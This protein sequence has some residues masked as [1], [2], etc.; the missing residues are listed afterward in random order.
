MNR[1]RAMVAAGALAS[2][3]AACSNVFEYPAVSAEH[4]A[5]SCR[6]GVDDDYD[7][8]TDCDDLDCDGFCVEDDLSTCTNRRDDD[9]D[10]LA[11]A[12][13]PRCWP[14]L[15]PV[16]RRCAEARGVEIVET[17][18]T[19]RPDTIEAS[20]RSYGAD[21]SS[22]RSSLPAVTQAR[23]SPD[24][25]DG[26]EDG[27]VR[28]SGRTAP[29]SPGVLVATRAFAGS[30][31]R[32]LLSLRAAVPAR[33]ALEVALVPVDLAPS[34][35]PPAAGS[36]ATLAVVVDRSPPWTL[37][38]VVEGA[39]HETA[40]A[41]PPCPA[42]APCEHVT[43]S[44]EGVEL[45]ARV[46]RDDVVEAEV[47]A[48]VPASASLSPSRLVL[49]GGSTEG[50][51][52][53]LLDDLHL[54]VQ[55]D[56]P[57][58]FVDPQIPGNHCDA[59]AA[60]A[61]PGRT[62]SVARNA[63]GGFCA[64]TASST[65]PVLLARAV[66][67]WRSLDGVTWSPSPPSGDPVFS[68][69][70]PE[71]VVGAGVAADDGGT[72]AVVAIESGGMTRL[73]FAEGACDAWSA[74]EEGPV[75]GDAEAP[76]YVVVDGR[77]HVFFTRPP[78]EQT[79]RT[80]WRLPRGSV[81][82]TLVAELSAD[83]NAPVS[84]QRV[85]ARDL[86][87]ASPTSGV[88]GAGVALRVAEES[89]LADL[90]V[91]APEP[92][93]SLRAAP[94]SY[95]G[96]LAF[97][98]AR[99]LAAALS[100]GEEGGFLMYSG[101]SL[102]G[103][104]PG[105]TE[106]V[107]SI[108]TALL[109]PFGGAPAVTPRVPPRGC[110]DGT[111]DA[112]ETCALCET[113][114]ACPGGLLIADAFSN[115]Q[116]W[117]HV[118]KDSAHGAVRYLRVDPPGLSWAG[119]APAWSF[120]PLERSI[121]GDF[122]LSFD[123]LAGATDRDGWERPCS[124]YVGLGAPPPP[125][126]AAGPEGVFARLKLAERCVNRYTTFPV[127]RSGDA[128]FSGP[129][130]EEEAACVGSDYLPIDARTR[131]VLTRRAGSIRVSTPLAGHCGTR[132]ATVDYAGALPDL[133]AVLVGFG[134]PPL[135]GCAPD[136]GGGTITNLSLRLL[137]HPEACPPGHARCG[138]G[139]VEPSCVDTSRS[140]EHCGACGHGCGALEICRAGECVCSEA[141]EVLECDGACVDSKTSDRHCGNCGN[142]CRA[143]CS[144]GVCDLLYGTCAEPAVVPRGGGRF[145]IDLT[146]TDDLK[147]T[148]VRCGSTLE[149]VA[150][151]VVF[152][153]TPEKSGTGIVDVDVGR[154]VR[155]VLLTLTAASNSECSSWDVCVNKTYA[156]PDRILA[157]VV[158]GTPYLLSVG[159]LHPRGD[160][161][162][163]ALQVGVAE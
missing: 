119:G 62:V 154:D 100:F 117:Q 139:P 67:A 78:N 130:N 28:F 16:A 110:G 33:S 70:P 24:A 105:R 121:A 94:A 84:V 112:G 43:L 128:V 162:T 141:P 36:E 103:W 160:L 57:C 31:Q 56:W 95:E 48:P 74:L 41:S 38:L 150:N 90:R 40:L 87:L 76:S 73:V 159:L 39:R 135:A 59:R 2:S 155:D 98:D 58:G 156:S 111:C 13:D 25:S 104:V 101:S 93:F 15:A 42:G 22:D 79:G 72:Y 134:G 114:C 157:G 75:L 96:Q 123:V 52:F 126:L 61:A 51:D 21:V 89:N 45:V 1:L 81:S 11:D 146:R 127:V 122:E 32:F 125:D 8:K 137:S 140:P 129:K 37:A 49:T 106:N 143:F 3:I 97:D 26:R 88:L 47:R 149:S 69:A 153:W 133:G 18:D 116:A 83:V 20:F 85:G 66:T 99:V 148:T 115:R 12:A 7:G 120:L 132:D 44:Q 34:L 124:V 142:R 10:G 17:F 50:D 60:F 53:T 19:Q 9:G 163:I 102:Q 77:H 6:N 147:V 55:P 152:V 82:A 107:V 145:S 71:S 63:D 86:I 91:V 29:E 35:A 113:D 151:S 14:A 4:D 65:D 109:R 5:G 131:V 92:F 136:V 138:D 108:G 30:L 54:H 23:R 68:V 144:G 27:L 64:L 161:R 80:L 46:S 158:A 118:S